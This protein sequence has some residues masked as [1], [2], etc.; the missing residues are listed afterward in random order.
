M[1]LRQGERETILQVEDAT[2]EKSPKRKGH[3]PCKGQ[4]G[5]VVSIGEGPT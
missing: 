3:G 1:F 4:K 2:S 5:H